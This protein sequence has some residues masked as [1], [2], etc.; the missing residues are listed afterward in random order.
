M[1]KYI[2]LLW[3]PVCLLV[4]L[5]LFQGT[6]FAEE[7]KIKTKDGTWNEKLIVSFDVRWKDR[8]HIVLENISVKVTDNKLLTDS[9]SPLSDEARSW[10]AQN[11]A[12]IGGL[13]KDIEGK[14]AGEFKDGNPFDQ[15][16]YYGKDICGKNVEIFKVHEMDAKK[17]GTIFVDIGELMT[18]QCHRLLAQ[19]GD[20]TK[21]YQVMAPKQE[22]F[23]SVWFRFTSTSSIQNVFTDKEFKATNTNTPNVFFFND[24]D[25]GA[26][27]IRVE[28]DKGKLDG[29]DQAVTGTYETCDTAGTINN[30]TAWRENKAALP[31]TPPGT[32]PGTG[33]TQDDGCEVQLLNPLTWLMCPLIEGAI[34]AVNTLDNAITSLLTVPTQGPDSYFD[35]SGGIGNSG[36]ALFNVWASFRYIALSIVVIAGLVMII[37]QAFSFG[38]FDAYTIKKVLPKILIG[39]IGISV[40]W[41]VCKFMIDVF[42]ELGVGVRS[43]LYG[44]FKDMP[45][46]KFTAGLNSLLGI[47][48]GVLIIGLGVVGILSFVATALLAVM[49]AFGI[50]IFRQILII[51]LVV[52]APVAIACWILPNTEKVWKMWWDFF[53][54]S[55]VVFPII[56]LFIAGGRVVAQ[57]ATLANTGATTLNTHVTPTLFAFIGDAQL[58]ANLI[59]VAQSQ[60]NVGT[61]FLM[62]TIAF[63]AYFGPYFALPAAFRLAGGAIATVGGMAND[64]GRG[65]FDRLKQGRQK[66]MSDRVSRAT[67]GGLYNKNTRRG[68]IGNKIAG[69]AF[70]PH[71]YAALYGDKV[72]RKSGKLV[73]K[74][75]G[76]KST[77]LSSRASQIMGGIQDQSVEETQKVFQHLNN[78]GFNDKAY[79]A[80]TGAWRFK[81]KQADGRTTLD[82][83]ESAGLYDSKTGMGKVPTSHKEIMAMSNLLSNSDD[84]TER[85]AGVALAGQA[86]YLSKLNSSPETTLASIQGA[87]AM[88]WAQHGFAEPED[89]AKVYNSMAGPNGANRE[90]AAALVGRA[91]ILGQ[92]KRIDLKAGYGVLVGKDGTASSVYDNPGRLSEMVGT[93]KQH[94]LVNAKAG[95]IKDMSFQAAMDA[96]GNVIKNADGTDKL[97]MREGG[98]LDLALNAKNKDGTPDL[99]RMQATQDAIMLGAS[100]FSSSDADAKLLWNQMAESVPGLA[101]RVKASDAAQADLRSRGEAGGGGGGGDATNVTPPPP[102]V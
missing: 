55:L 7:F 23:R 43:L 19:S 18:S 76:F 17:D 15:G 75:D 44:P 97:E 80:L 45:G 82:H 96:N 39:V 83:L 86:G 84:E 41:Y 50:L 10:I 24:G 60:Q 33:Q 26:C 34:L 38:I 64:R 20:I 12:G 98:I 30:V 72:L 100:S 11:T 6:A 49:I 65:A 62:S 78:N 4:G 16:A 8:A 53:I 93:F 27:N 36:K 56:T 73:G 32:T 52:T 29:N 85:I 57:V 25:S 70:E 89:L 95:A 81:G 90:Q 35:E 54:R 59:H 102:G 48:T 66:R 46:V 99:R 21:V 2:L 47:G 74:K 28:L 71:N 51:L 67:Q 69:T 13:G 9:D 101:E 92:D 37:S 61:D 1:R 40:S 79:A 22:Q 31:T 3:F 91:Q 94:D 68:R 63:I 87:G 5:F 14:S 77:F 42:N 88:G 58:K